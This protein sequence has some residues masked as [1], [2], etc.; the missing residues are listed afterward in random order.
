MK[1]KA[2]EIYDYFYA[3]SGNHPAAKKSSLYLVNEMIN[4]LQA[5]CDLLMLKEEMTFW[6]GVKKELKNK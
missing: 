2:K 6:K 1:D 5:V 4:R 3:I